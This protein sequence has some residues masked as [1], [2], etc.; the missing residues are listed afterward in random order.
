MRA[1]ALSSSKT[2]T[3]STPL[4]AASSSARSTAGITGRP[5]PLSRRTEASELSPTTSASP[6]ARA[7]CR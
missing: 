7:A 3:A 6:R 1:S 2:T 4:T 5:G